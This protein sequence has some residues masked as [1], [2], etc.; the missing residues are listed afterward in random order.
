MAAKS[1]ANSS[2]NG[3]EILV[4][5]DAVSLCFLVNRRARTLRVV[6]F[7]AGP[8][9]AKRVVVNAIAQR[10]GVDKIY[11]L[12]ERDEVATWTKLGFA[13]EGNI[14]A[15]YKRSDAFFLGA[16]VTPLVT[17]PPHGHR[18][19]PRSGVFPAAHSLLQDAE[20]AEAGVSAAEATIAEGK[21]I[22][23]DLAPKALPAAKLSEISALD[24]KKYVSS[25]QKS[26]RALTAFEPFGR[27]VER[28]YF[29]I[30][31][32]AGWEIVASTETQG[33]FGNAFIELLTRPAEGSELVSFASAVRTLT[34]HLL[35]DGIVS[36]FALA[37]SHDV[38]LAAVFALNGFRRTGLLAKHLLVRRERLN[39]IVWSRKLAI[40]GED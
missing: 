34:D 6:D 36:S 30:A 15:F 31:G 38:E 11:T 16:V 17:P 22:A 32:R 14:P 4:H 12:V 19:E 20:A 5:N 9:P 37:A 26:G 40:P 18:T 24:A 29:V 10:E 1:Y 39:A 8:S 7:R 25:A 13:R 35:K 21:R 23:K 3:D 2:T 28:R 27:D 33:C